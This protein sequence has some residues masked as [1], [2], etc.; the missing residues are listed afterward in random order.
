MKKVFV[1]L[2]LF[3]GII[4]C[5]MGQNVSVIVNGANG[6]YRING[7]S[8]S[9]DIGGV[10]ASFNWCECYLKNYNKADV[11][12]LCV[13]GYT[14]NSWEYGKGFLKEE[15]ETTINCVIPA[16]GQKKVTFGTCGDI[17]GTSAVDGYVKGM[18]VR[19]LAQ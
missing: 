4:V 13:I 1:I 15:K 8:S 5:A 9:Q 10:E 6:E 7:I 16:N 11:T 18:I 19:K 14:Q 3:L 12:V 2:T 17:R